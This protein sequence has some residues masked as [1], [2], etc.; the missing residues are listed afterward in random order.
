MSNDAKPFY[1]THVQLTKYQRKEFAKLA[2]IRRNEERHA[3]NN[4]PSVPAPVTDI[5]TLQDA[6]A[7]LTQLPPARAAE[8]TMTA[9]AVIGL[10][11]V[12]P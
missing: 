11:N 7:I 1:A 4:R 2:R 12:V 6:M 5:M 9:L 3:A 10:D 8:L